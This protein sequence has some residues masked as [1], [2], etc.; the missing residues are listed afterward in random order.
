MPTFITG[1]PLPPG[2]DRSIDDSICWGR[3]QWQRTWRPFA[4]QWSQPGLIR[5]AAET[6]GS[7]AIHSS[8]ILGFSTGSLRD[9]SPK[10][11]LAIGLFNE[12]LARSNGHPVNS[13]QPSDASR[14]ARSNGHEVSGEGPRCPGSLE[15]LW[16]GYQHLRT[17]DGG[18]MG[19]LDVFAA[20]A[21]LSDLGVALEREIPREAE[22]A[23]C[24]ALG[25]HLRMALAAN[26]IDWMEELPRLR[27]ELPLLDPL[28]H[29][30]PV[31]GDALTSNLEE[32]ATCIGST[33][34]ELWAN[35]ITPAVD[36]PK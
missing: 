14:R 36:L 34:D 6:L 15:H 28:L 20:V 11:L 31:P 1:N 12:A 30:K 33:A 22:E 13:Q 21:G 27:A 4:R 32:V 24:K 10:L 23:V 5:V 8:Q 25:R 17:A 2:T 16:R 19:P 3:A 29:G 18:V 9:P 26:G 7:R 35:I